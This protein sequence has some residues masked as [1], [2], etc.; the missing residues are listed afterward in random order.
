MVNDILGN[1]FGTKYGDPQE[2]VLDPIL[3]VMYINSIYE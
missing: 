1:E 2:S 3:F